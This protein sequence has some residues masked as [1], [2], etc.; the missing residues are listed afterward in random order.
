M[1]SNSQTQTSSNKNPDEAEVY[2][3]DVGKSMIKES[4]PSTDNTAKHIIIVAGILEGLYFHAVTFS[5]F[6][7][8]AVGHLR[9]LAYLTPIAL[10]LVSLGFSLLVL[11]PRLYQLDI[12]SHVDCQ[13]LH[14]HIVRRKFRY[15]KIAMLFLLLGVAAIFIALFVYL[16]S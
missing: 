12:Y 4:L 14:G 1:S 15:L 8:G 6:K 16:R 10:L 11:F 2:W 3:R 5:E 13:F 9:L 7:V